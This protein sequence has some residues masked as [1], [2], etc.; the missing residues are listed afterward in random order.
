MYYFFFDWNDPIIDKALHIVCIDKLKNQ[1]YADM[2]DLFAPKHTKSYYRDAL[3]ERHSILA[4]LYR[5]PTNN[6]GQM[7][8]V[9]AD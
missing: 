9:W 7:L 8:E 6:K 2:G 5:K 3:D 1:G 4:D